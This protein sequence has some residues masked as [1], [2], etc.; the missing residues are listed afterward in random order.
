MLYYYYIFFLHKIELHILTL[1]SEK[2]KII[3]IP[4][5]L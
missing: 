1:Y 5:N 4:K 3:K 2:Q